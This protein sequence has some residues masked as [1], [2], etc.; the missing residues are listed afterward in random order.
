MSYSAGEHGFI[1]NRHTRQYV[2]H[3]DIDSRKICDVMNIIM[4]K[5]CKVNVCGYNTLDD[6]YWGKKFEKGACELYF[7]IT[8]KNLGYNNS[9]LIIMPTFG[10][11]KVI[12]ELCNTI[13]NV[14]RMCEILD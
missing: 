4:V 5:Y 3:C 7:Q 6:K 12:T 10:T 2:I 9:S 8:V 11:L 1:P 13:K 14:I